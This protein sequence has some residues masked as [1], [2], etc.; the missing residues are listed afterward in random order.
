MMIHTKMLR[1][2]EDSQGNRLLLD[3]VMDMARFFFQDSINELEDETDEDSKKAVEN[4]K[5]ALILIDNFKYLT[6]FF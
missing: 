1:E 4:Y 6:G 2:L 3:D 5:E